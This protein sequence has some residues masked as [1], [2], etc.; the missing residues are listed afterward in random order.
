MRAPRQGRPREVLKLLAEGYTMKRVAAMLNVTE[1]TV[2]F[3]KYQMMAQLRIRSTAELVLCA[4]K[5]HLV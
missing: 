1:R 5:Q 3:H 4:M 2:G